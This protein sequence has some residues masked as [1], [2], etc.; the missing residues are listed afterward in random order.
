MEKEKYWDNN[1][2]EHGLYTYK[3]DEEVSLKLFI[4]EDQALIMIDCLTTITSNPI[5]L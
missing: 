4:E 5:N 2:E 3:I 1:E